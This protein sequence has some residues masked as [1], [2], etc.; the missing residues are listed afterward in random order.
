MSL[1]GANEVWEVSGGGVRKI[2]VDALEYGLA[3]AG[4]EDLRGGDP[5]FNADVVRRVLDGEEGHVRN[6]V[7]FNSAAALVICGAAPDLSQGLEIARRS[8]DS[9]AARGSLQRFV[10]ASNEGTV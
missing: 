9:G 7:L 2:T 10:E 4:L 6:V 5:R 8:I 1:S 3:R